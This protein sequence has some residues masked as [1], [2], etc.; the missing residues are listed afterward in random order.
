[1][2]NQYTPPYTL[3]YPFGWQALV[4][5]ICDIEKPPVVITCVAA[6]CDPALW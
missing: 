4:L 6:L 3:E 1:M 2:A 5:N